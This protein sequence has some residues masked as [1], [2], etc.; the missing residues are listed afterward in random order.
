MGGAFLGIFGH[1]NVD[2]IVDATKDPPVEHGPFFGGVAGNI[3]V[4]ASRFGVPVRLASVIGRNFP[5]AYLNLLKQLKVD[6]SYLQENDGVETSTCRMTTFPDGSQRKEIF[7]GPQNEKVRFPQTF[8]KGLRYLHVS[9]GLPEACI[10]AMKQGRDGGFTVAFDPGADLARH[11]REEDLMSA[12]AC[13][14]MF[15]VNEEEL[16]VALGLLGA[17]THNALLNLVGTLLVTKTGRGSLLVTKRGE[18]RI[19]AVK[20]PK[21]VDP[22]GAGDAY[23]SGVYAGLFRGYPMKDCCILGAIAASECIQR[24]GAQ[25]GLES[26]AE[27]EKRYRAIKR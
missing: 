7:H 15:F 26:W 22:T 4:G 2:W 20:V 10:C 18:V 5:A 13:S 11:Y 12:L 27:L 17:R 23:R 21:V 16:K 19:P 6:L 9:T 1:V 14:D 8:V 24:E 3:A 25:E